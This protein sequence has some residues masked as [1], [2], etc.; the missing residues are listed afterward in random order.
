MKIPWLRDQTKAGWRP[1]YIEKKFGT[2]EN[3]GT[4]GIVSQAFPCVPR[5]PA[6]SSLTSSKRAALQLLMAKPITIEE[7]ITPDWLTNI[8]R[9]NGH[10][11]QGSVSGLNKESFKTLFSLFYSLEAHYSNDANPTL[12]SKMLLKLPLPNNEAS[13]KMGKDEVFIYNAIKKAM[14]DPP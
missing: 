5:F 6:N 3:I 2:R 7:E 14:A 10:L 11:I 1:K 4:H 9:R 13:M 12:P 8:L